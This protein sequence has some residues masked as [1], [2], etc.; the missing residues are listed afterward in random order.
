MTE[1]NTI[2]S[3]EMRRRFTIE[4]E[5]RLRPEGADQYRGLTREM[6]HDPWTERV[7][8]AP[9]SD[10][11]TFT[12]IGGGFAGL[13]TGAQL[14]KR[15][16]TDVRIVDRA[17]DFGGVWYWN[18]YPGLMCDS[19]AALYLPLLEETGYMPRMKYAFQPE[20][21]EHCQRLG[22]HYGLY[23][24]ALFHTRL[25]S[26]DWDE[27]AGVWR[28]VTD[29]GDSFTTTYL[30]LGLGFF[31]NPKLPGIPG[32]ENFKGKTF[33]AARWDYAYTGGAPGDTQLDRLGD[34]RVAVLGTGATSVQCV[35]PLSAHAKELF[36]FQ[37]TPSA[38]SPR[39][40]MPTDEA[41]F[42]SIA[43][44]GWQDRY[45]A[46]YVRDWSGMWGQPF[47]REPVQDLLSDGIARMA[48]RVRS[49][50]LSVP[51]ETRNP[52]TV[53]EALD[54]ADIE[55]VAQVHNHIAGIVTD[56]ETAEKLKPWYRPMCKR[57]TFNDDYLLAFNRPNTHLIDTDGKG[58]EGITENGVVA[59]GIEYPVDCIIYASGY[60]FAK[61]PRKALD[62][63]IRGVD[64]KDL[65]DHWRDGVRSLHG[66]H[67]HGF[68]NL[69]A[70]QL[71][72][73]ADFAAN[74][75]TNWQDT[76]ETIAIIV[77]H[78]EKS[79]LKRVEADEA[80]EVAWAQQIAATPPMPDVRDCTPGLLTFEG[81]TDPQISSFSGMPDGPRA[82]FAMIG[83]WKKS[84]DFAGLVFSS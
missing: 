29:R 22:R 55:V 32:I 20:I 44:P 82:F 37:R 56:S 77:E 67:M 81:G 68:P 1:T 13:L 71:A 30:G 4:R 8:R 11:V 53:K 79:G 2:N 33:H 17:G 70:V 51:E 43:T 34:K 31:A 78:M 23:E 10:H 65:R 47:S 25:E 27:A 28:I 6:D 75:P 18:R 40:N 50:I 83:G 58:V 3:E 66:M 41:W 36:V 14:A 59:K 49:V 24:N 21:L 52:A 48:E 62:F 61:D 12:F 42:K 64:G 76:G 19:P 9:V 26:A 73:G 16:I 60:D 46:S 69:F 35:G 15:G 7:E 54:R 74:I 39:N 38:V 84:G 5:K 57:P 63:A 80:D 72:Q 45:H